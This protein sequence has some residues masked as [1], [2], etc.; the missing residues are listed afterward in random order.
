MAVNGLLLLHLVG[1]GVWM[2]CVAVEILIE[3]R[4]SNSTEQH[5]DTAALHQQIDLLVEVPALLLVACTGVAMLMEAK[6]TALLIIKVVFAVVAIISNAVCVWI[7][8]K[9]QQATKIGIEAVNAESERMNKMGI[10]LLSSWF[11]T[12]AIGAYLW[13]GS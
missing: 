3:V 12:L 11:L 2:G 4:R 1:I 6:L 7:V 5:F 10:P 13:L 9:R 8:F